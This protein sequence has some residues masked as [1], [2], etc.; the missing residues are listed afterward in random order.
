MLMCSEDNKIFS[1][2][3]CGILVLGSSAEFI[4][5]IKT[6]LVDKKSS[7]A[8]FS[9]DIP[10]LLDSLA[11]IFYL[12]PRFILAEGS[13]EAVRLFIA[14]NLWYIRRANARLF[15][16]MTNQESTE[17][18]RWFRV[19]AYGVFSETASRHEIMQA[20]RRNSHCHHIMPI[21]LQLLTPA[22]MGVVEGLILG[23]TLSELAR[24]QERSIKT[25]STQ[26]LSAR[27][28]LKARNDL[29]LMLS[30]LSAL[31]FGTRPEWPAGCQAS[32]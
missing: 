19:C 22:E 30:Y 4:Q 1:L 28:K 17:V 25:L 2:H 23:Y 15:F 27:N 18:R 26:K 24:F 21:Q 12:Q 13:S 20:L 3:F 10:V 31:S 14:S 16:S 9:S 11:D 6:L 7:S 5:R 29:Q 32:I 8:K